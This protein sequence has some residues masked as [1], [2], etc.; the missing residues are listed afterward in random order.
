MIWGVNDG[1]DTVHVRLIDSSKI[2]WPGHVVVALLLYV[3]LLSNKV[4]FWLLLKC[5]LVSFQIH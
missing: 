2:V 5:V 3:G 4:V 1:F